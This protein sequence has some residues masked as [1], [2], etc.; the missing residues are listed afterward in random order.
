MH[1][2][3]A[4]C[5]V[6]LSRRAQSPTLR[7]CVKIGQDGAVIGVCDGWQKTLFMAREAVYVNPD[8]V[9]DACTQIGGGQ[10]AKGLLQ[11]SAK[12]GAPGGAWRRQWRPEVSRS[13]RHLHAL[14]SF[15]IDTG[16]HQSTYLP[17]LHTPACWFHARQPAPNDAWRRVLRAASKLLPGPPPVHHSH[18]QHF[19]G[20]QR[21]IG[22]LGAQPGG[23]ISLRQRTSAPAAANLAARAM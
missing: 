20:Q 14:G 10:P 7:Q 12:R 9:H 19:H 13:H 2:N 18:P 8:D 4:N 3:Y 23:N 21:F 16:L 6:P 1:I 22:T 11:T 15:T 5:C 17:V